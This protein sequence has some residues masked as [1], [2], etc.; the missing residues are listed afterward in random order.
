[1]TKDQT[2]IKHYDGGTVLTGDAVTLYRW[3]SIQQFIG[4]YMKTGMIPTR[5]VTISKMIKMAGEITGKK[6][7]NNRPG[8]QQAY[9]DLQVSCD[10]LRAAMPVIDERTKP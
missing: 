9:D 1:M 6:Y 3:K 8:W 7:K 4:L 2:A 10:T 5:G